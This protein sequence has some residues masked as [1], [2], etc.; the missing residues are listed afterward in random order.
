M[1]EKIKEKHIRIPE[2]ILPKSFSYCK[3]QIIELLT[4]SQT[5]YENKRYSG[6]VAYSIL[7]LEEIQKLSLIRMKIREKKSIFEDEWKDLSKGGSHKSKLANHYLKPLIGLQDVTQK[8]YEHI[9]NT[10]KNLGSHQIFKTNLEEL[11]KKSTLTIRRLEQLNEIKK[12][13]WYFEGHGNIGHTLSSLYEERHIATLAKYL[14]ELTNFLFHD[15]CLNYEFPLKWYHE[16]PAE[17]NIMIHTTHWKE[18]QRY[19]ET[20]ETEDY[21]KIITVACHIIDKYP[22]KIEFSRAA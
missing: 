6:S 4:D 14:F 9:V 19:Y 10:E 3:N 15:E 5:L 13:C 8:E 17:V 22:Q 12:G 18:I 2:D 16:I 1:L 20:I 7:A 11:K 21:K